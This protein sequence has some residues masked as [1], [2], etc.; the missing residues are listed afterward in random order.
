MNITRTSGKRVGAGQR[1]LVVAGSNQPT[2]RKLWNALA[3]VVF[4]LLSVPGLA[5][6]YRFSTIDVPGATATAVNAN[7]THA[8]AG[9][10]A[11]TDGIAHGFVLNKGVFTTIPDVLDSKPTPVGVPP[12]LIQTTI[13]GINA[14]G[15]FTGIYGDGER[16]HAFVEGATMPLEPDGALQSQAG[17]INAQGQ[18]VGTYRDAGETRHGFIWRKGNFTTFNVPGDDPV[19]GTVAFGINDPGEVVGN[20]V[21]GPT[22]VRRGFL[23]SSK[24]EYTTF[25][26]PGVDFTAPQGINNAGQ[27]VGFY[28]DSKDP[29]FLFHGFVLSKGVFKTVDFPDARETQIFSINAKGEIVGTYF[30]A[31]GKQHGFLGVPVR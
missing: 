26:V 29:D 1:E 20:Y 18:V 8:I 15:R 23:R 27:I 7:S 24:G 22:G 25:D 19:L 10:F 30:T 16:P 9:E 11:G 14:Q 28:A 31:D 4:G 17:F 3:A 5:Q 2:V 12:K 13:N 6:E 21:D